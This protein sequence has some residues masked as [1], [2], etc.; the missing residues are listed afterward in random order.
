MDS[1]RVDI[2]FSSSVIGG[3]IVT[4]AVLRLLGLA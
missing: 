2:V 1:T 3:A 4:G